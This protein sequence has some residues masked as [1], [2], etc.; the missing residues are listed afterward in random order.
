MRK[1]L[2][3]V[4]ACKHIKSSENA[5]YGY[6]HYFFGTMKVRLMFACMNLKKLA[7]MKSQKCLQILEEYMK[8]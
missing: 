5:A 2:Q 7:K 1:S 8:I 3:K 6:F 4:S